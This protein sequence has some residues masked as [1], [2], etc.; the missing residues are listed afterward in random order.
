MSKYN[1]RNCH[2]SSFWDQFS[3]NIIKQL[4]KFGVVQTLSLLTEIINGRDLSGN[5]F[6]DIY[7]YQLALRIFLAKDF[8]DYKAELILIRADMG[9]A[10]IILY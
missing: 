4:E 6:M 5:S 10:T 2:S 9:L 1:I 3:Q 8:F 7:L